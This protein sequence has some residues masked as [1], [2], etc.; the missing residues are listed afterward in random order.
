MEDGAGAGDGQEGGLNAYFRTRVR[1][2]VLWYLMMRRFFWRRI[3]GI[4]MGMI[5]IS[6]RL[7]KINVHISGFSMSR[8]MLNCFGMPNMFFVDVRSSN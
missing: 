5:F 8:L 1:E 3:H 4:R 2:G 7:A 6:Q